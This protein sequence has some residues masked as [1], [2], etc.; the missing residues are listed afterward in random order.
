MIESGIQDQFEKERL[1]ALLVALDVSSY[2]DEQEV[3][4]ENCEEIV[5]LANEVHHL[6]SVCSESQGSEGIKIRNHLDHKMKELINQW[7]D[8]MRKEGNKNSR[9]YSFKERFGKFF[10]APFWYGL[11]PCKSRN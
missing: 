8:M 7:E 3:R 4:D 11:I 2:L 1:F 9:F 6:A 5:A 10:H